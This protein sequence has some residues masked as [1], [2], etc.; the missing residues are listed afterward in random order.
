MAEYNRRGFFGRLAGLAAGAVAAK[1]LP[2]PEPVKLPVTYDFVWHEY[3][4]HYSSGFAVFPSTHSIIT[5][6]A[7]SYAPAKKSRKR[8][9]R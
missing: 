7:R 3:P 5:Q 9:K 1:A 4:V 2:E 6:G 8:K